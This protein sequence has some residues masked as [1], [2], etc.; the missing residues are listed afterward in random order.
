MKPTSLT[1]VLLALLAACS[2]PGGATRGEAPRLAADLRLPEAGALLVSGDLVVPAGEHRRAAREEGL[3]VLR[4]LRG[5]TLDLTGAH[6][7]GADPGAAPSD[8]TGRCL[9]VRDCADVRLVGGRLSGYR[10]GLWI[11]NSTGVTVEGLVVDP[12]AGARL[13]GVGGPR[14]GGLEALVEREGAGVV[15]VD[16]A[17]VHLR[18]LRVRG[19][20]VGV[21]GLRLDRCRVEDADLAYLSARGVA[22]EGST[23][24]ELLGNRCD[25]VSRGP[26]GDAAGLWLGSGCE[27]ILVSGNLSRGGDAG[28]VDLDGR[29][30]RWGWN[31][32]SGN[33]R[34]ALE[35]VGGEAGWIVRNRVAG[36]AGLRLDGAAGCVVLGNELGEVR[37][38]GLRITGGGGALV[39]NNRLE[40]CDAGVE[41]VEDSGAAPS[42]LG[43]NGFRDNLQDLVLEEVTGVEFWRND[44]A[45]GA[46]FVHVDGLAG[47]PGDG[48]REGREAWALLADAE[49]DLPSGR[50]VRSRLGRARPEPPVEVGRAAGWAGPAGHREPPFAPS[51]PSSVVLGPHGPWDPESGAPRPAPPATR[52]PL[53][54]ARWQA[55]WF[56]WDEASD[57]RGDLDRWRSRRFDDPVRGEVAG[58]SDPWGGDLAVRER[59]P[60]GSF[61]LMARTDLRLP[62]AG[63]FVLRV[64]SDDGVRLRI[65]GEVVIEDWSWHPARDEQRR[66]ELAA[67]LH[68]LELEYFQVDGAA[69][70]ELGL[71]E[72]AAFP[73]PAPVEIP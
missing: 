73:D 12:A 6:L 65:D 52:G 47:P 14:P 33:R 19:G 29:G 27:G 45:G 59:L 55:T 48:A 51:P 17:D 30:N 54:G 23:R 61:G 67:G 15:V 36:G 7:I 9:V 25:A 64:R 8:F 60:V 31:D 5:V 68:R 69:V 34:A 72:D 39:A 40:G 53:A 22:L 24:C 3:L 63:V 18:D 49:G 46:P 32:L 50:A 38:A 43:G 16:S 20:A 1:P 71:L 10:V 44:F 70:L 42:W 66:L 26:A 35:L 62:E 11:E 21:A 41:L 57:P 58:W 2:A 56:T 4:G 37:G 13:D 28:G